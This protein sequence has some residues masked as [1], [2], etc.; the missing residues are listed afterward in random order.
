M[1]RCISLSV[2]C[3][4]SALIFTPLTGYFCDY[5][6]TYLTHDSVSLLKL[7]GT[8]SDQFPTTLPYILLQPN[9]RKTHN[10]G[11]KHKDNVRE[12]YE[13]WYKDHFP[14]IVA[15]GTATQ[16]YTHMHPYVHPLR[17]TLHCRQACPSSQCRRLCRSIPVRCEIR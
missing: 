7:Y 6:G 15:A 17:L 16:T 13:K 14:E 1:R 12:Y 3:A 8:K 10:N 2:F 5:C 4:P 11:V 9:V